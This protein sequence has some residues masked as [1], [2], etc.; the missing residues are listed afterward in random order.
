MVPNQPGVILAL[1]RNRDP[2]DFVVLHRVLG[3][4]Y[5]PINVER[6]MDEH[7]K[8]KTFPPESAPVYLAVWFQPITIPIVK[9]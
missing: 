7:R 9:V 5:P 6:E 2:G 3:T 4:E 8:L 1:H